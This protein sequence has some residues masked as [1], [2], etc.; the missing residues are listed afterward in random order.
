M[1]FTLDRDGAASRLGVSSRTID[2]HIQAGRIRTRRIGKKMFLED[3]D[4]ETLRNMDPARREEDYVI[5]IDDDKNT[6]PKHEIVQ[7]KGQ[8]NLAVADS[9]AVTE[10]VRLYEE[11]R[12]IIA[13]KDETIQDLSYKLGK[14][15]TELRNTIPLVDYNKATFLLESAKTKGSEDTMQYSQ[16]IENLEKEISKRNG[17]ILS[18]AL[19]FVLVL[20]F[21]VVFFFFSPQL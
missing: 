21:S 13:R 14:A 17:A 20:A 6:S 1:A 10:L 7:P 4:V 9:T 11:T 15:E 12:G 3:E 19:L 16:K 2:R 8:K 5:I 18:L